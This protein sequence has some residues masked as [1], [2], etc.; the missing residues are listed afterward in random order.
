M[1]EKLSNALILA[2]VRNILQPNVHEMEFCS[3]NRMVI[4]AP[5]LI[6][7]FTVCKLERE[8]NIVIESN[9]VISSMLKQLNNSARTKAAR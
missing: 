3:N 1:K 4:L 9:Y 5:K 7:K 6:G 8:T 2:C